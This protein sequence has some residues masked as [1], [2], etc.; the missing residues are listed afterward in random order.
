MELIR[1]G[2]WY[3]FDGDDNV[4]TKEKEFGNIVLKRI[5]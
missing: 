3:D 4:S 2:D 5:R 1:S